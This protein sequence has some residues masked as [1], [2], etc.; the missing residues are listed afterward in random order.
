MEGLQLAR[1][2][3]HVRRD[4][5]DL[6]YDVLGERQNWSEHSLYL[7]LGYW[8]EA[9]GIDEASAALVQLL[10]ERAEL[11]AGDRVFNPGFGFGDEALHWMQHFRPER[12]DG[13]NVSS[14]QVDSAR[15]RVREAGLEDRIG[16]SVGNAV[17]AGYADA[18]FDRVLAVETAFHFRT[19]EKFFATARR[20]L[21][22][23]GVLGLTDF[24]LGPGAPDSLRRQVGFWIGCLSWQIPS[25]NLYP[26]DGYVR[27]LRAAG[28]E[29]IDV[30][31]ITADVIPPFA[32]YLRPRLDGHR[33]I[34]RYHPLARLSAR[35]QLDLGFLECWR[36]CLIT[37]RKPGDQSVQTTTTLT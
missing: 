24:V 33:L 12:I 21:R 18:T 10:G 11:A 8:R 6:V 5:A 37:A 20:V 13:L 32:R 34:E 28:F 7:N 29:G 26:I 15:R 17:T 4:R 1:V 16:L 2:A 23:G 14:L 27:R 31:D 30:L 9:T 25:C 22:P 3:A 35:L 36:Y 19:R